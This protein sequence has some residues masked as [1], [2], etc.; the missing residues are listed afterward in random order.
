MRPRTGIIVL[1]TALALGLPRPGLAQH[2]HAPT[3]SD[4]LGTVAFENSCSAA[5]Q[6]PI[7]RAVALL[8]S[9]WFLESEKT[10]RAVL[11]Q[12]PTCAIATW[13]IAAAMM[14]NPLGGRGPSA[15]WA[16]RG[17][18]AIEQGQRYY[19]R[20]LEITGPGAG[21]PELAQVRAFLAGN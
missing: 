8:H 5:V 13:G 17:Q 10:F 21:R 1:L 18:A 3:A 14:E 20:L 4:H 16:Q 9:F 2:Q 7:Q 15:Q 11:V 6:A 19:A 12:D